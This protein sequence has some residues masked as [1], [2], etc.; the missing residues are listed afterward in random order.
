MTIRAGEP[1]LALILFHSKVTIVFFLHLFHAELSPERSQ[2]S[3]NGTLYLTPHFHHQNN[4]CIM[5]GSD[6]SHFN[7]SLTVNGKVT[8]Q[9]PQTITFEEKGEP[10]WNRA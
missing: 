6:E 9:C 4:S 5:M 8:R 10:K 1:A 3:E 7:V 2:V